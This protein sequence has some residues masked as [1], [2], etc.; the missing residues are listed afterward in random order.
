MANVSK[1]FADDPCSKL[2]REQMIITARILLASVT[3]LLIL[4]DRVDVQFILKSISIVKNDLQHI[5][6]ASN[7]E[8]LNQFY[9]QYGKDINDLNHHTQRRQQVKLFFRFIFF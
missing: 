6:N 5:F 4:A 1:I 2:K 9:K 3:H 7:Q 8:E